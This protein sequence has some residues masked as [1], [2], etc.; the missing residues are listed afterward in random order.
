MGVTCIN[1]LFQQIRESCASGELVV[2]VL[3]LVDL[4]PC[5][6]WTRFPMIVAVAEG[7]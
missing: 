5:S 6:F 2:G 4:T 7:Q 1:I 3:G